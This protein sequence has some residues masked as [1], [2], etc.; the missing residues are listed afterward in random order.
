MYIE[1]GTDGI[2]KG[3]NGDVDCFDTDSLGEV[4]D[5]CQFAVNKSMAL[6]EEV[7]EVMNGN[8]FKVLTN[9]IDHFKAEQK[10]RAE[11]ASE[12]FYEAEDDRHILDAKK[13]ITSYI[14]A[15]DKLYLSSAINTV[16]IC[17]RVISS[18]IN[19]SD[20]CIRKYK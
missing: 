9:I 7:T 13:V 17:N 10:A 11:K 18:G 15:I 16:T 6:F 4:L 19:Y 8:D 1:I 12:E 3:F 20:F 5:Q 14:R 2:I